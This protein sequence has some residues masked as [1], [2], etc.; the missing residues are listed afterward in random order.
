M[1]IP[2]VCQCHRSDCLVHLLDQVVTFWRDY[3]DR[4]AG[5]LRR[6]VEALLHGEPQ[7]L[8]PML[9]ESRPT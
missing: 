3:K 9:T 1:P 4:L 6:R 8:P 7:Q 5:R 2:V